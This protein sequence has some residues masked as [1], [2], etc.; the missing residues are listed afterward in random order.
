[1]KVFLESTEITALVTSLTLDR[2]LSMAGAELRLEAAC[3]PADRFVPKLNPVWGE[4]VTVAADGTVIFAGQIERADFSAAGL[5][6][7]LL[8][9]ERTALLARC[10]YGGALTGTP[11][12]A[13]RA[14]IAAAGLRPGVLWEREGRVALPVACG[15]SALA[16]VR[17]C[18]GGDCFPEERGG[19]VDLLRPGARAYTL[20]TAD[21]LSLSAA[22]TLEPLVT[23][24]EVRSGT[25]RV[26]A[27][28]ADPVWERDFGQRRAVLALDGPQSGAADQ[29]RAALRCA[30]RQAQA[31]L[32]GDLSARCGA[33]VALDHGAFGAA[34]AYLVTR[35]LHTLRD[36]VLLTTLG[37]ESI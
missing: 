30:R 29:A 37:L 9:L 31:V 6:L 15:R 2:S 7:T 25:G 13:A 36:G 22:N 20:G 10:E 11:A 19:A 16:A 33:R 24:A 35:V 32:R 21:L 26:L 14:V 18:Y 4:P 27:Q 3:A 23:G 8:C 28:C 17:A 12:Q 1:M 34:G 5:R